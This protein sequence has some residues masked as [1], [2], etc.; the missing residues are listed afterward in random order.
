MKK[1]WTRL[2]SVTLIISMFFITITVLKNNTELKREIGRNFQ[3]LNDKTNLF[4]SNT[5]Q[6]D[7]EEAI[8][9]EQGQQIV[10]SYQSQYTLL[11]LEYHA[12]ANN[13]VNKLASIL[14]EVARLEAILLDTGSWT[15]F[16]KERHQKALATIELILRDFSSING[17]DKYWYQLITKKDSQLIEYID[18]RI[19]S[20]W[21]EL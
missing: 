2:A 18:K 10:R 11:W 16:E 17:S 7:F 3:L 20:E 9:T 1:G 8:K 15:P 13:D 4:I 19:E 6:L 5:R 12:L 14:G 21:L